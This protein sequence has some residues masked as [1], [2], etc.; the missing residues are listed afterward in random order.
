MTP[1]LRLV[2]QGLCRPYA[3]LRDPLLWN[4]V[5]G[6]ELNQQLPF[7]HH[8]PV[9]HQNRYDPRRLSYG[10]RGLFTGYSS[11]PRN[12]KEFKDFSG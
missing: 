1:R 5:R 6:I 11:V 10:Q 8:L 4:H 3:C 2:H 7:P 12:V 9:F